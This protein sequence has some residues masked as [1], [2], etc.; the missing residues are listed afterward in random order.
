MKIANELKEQAPDRRLI[1][2]DE[3]DPD[4]G[5]GIFSTVPRH[6]TLYNKRSNYH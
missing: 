5:K 1:D 2:M 6:E 3:E 4:E